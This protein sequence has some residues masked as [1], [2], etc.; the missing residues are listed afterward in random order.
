MC[1]QENCVPLSQVQIDSSSSSVVG[2]YAGTMFLFFGMSRG[3]S[4]WHCNGDNEEQNIGQSIR[5]DHNR[6]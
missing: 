6:Q 5:A 3:R 4:H 2:D 1:F